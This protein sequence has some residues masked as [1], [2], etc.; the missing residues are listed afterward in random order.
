MYKHIAGKQN[1]KRSA[2]EEIQEMGDGRDTRS[3]GIGLETM[4]WHPFQ[5]EIKN[6]R[7][8]TFL[9]K[10]TGHAQWSEPVGQTQTSP[11][12]AD[13]SWAPADDKQGEISNEGGQCKNP[14]CKLQTADQG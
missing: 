4:D 6:F 9:Q 8:F 1:G 2:L 11:H 5:R 14:D 10:S 7:R 13:M 12:M 3:E